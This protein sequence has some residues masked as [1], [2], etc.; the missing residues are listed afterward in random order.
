[1]PHN[2]ICVWRQTNKCFWQ[3]S[4]CN[5]HFYSTNMQRLYA[6]IAEH[7]I[8]KVRTS[9]LRNNFSPLAIRTWNNHWTGHSPCQRLH[10]VKCAIILIILCNS[11]QTSIFI[12]QCA[13]YCAIGTKAKDCRPFPPLPKRLDF[14]CY[15][16]AHPFWGGENI[17]LH[18]GQ[19]AFRYPAELCSIVERKLSKQSCRVGFISPWCYSYQ[20]D[21]IKSKQR[22]IYSA[23][24]SSLCLTRLV[25]T[26]CSCILP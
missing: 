6:N 16:S 14:L 3:Y 8:M 7:F 5:C 1:M 13:S 24:K 11:Y 17:Q 20:S 23:L 10:H 25:L 2:Y 9:R 26:L 15:L 22:L 19:K 18:C 4:V 12:F 21:W